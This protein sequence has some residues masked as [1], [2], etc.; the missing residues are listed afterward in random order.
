MPVDAIA[1]SRLIYATTPIKRLPLVKSRLK[2]DYGKTVTF[3]Y[4]SHR[5]G[6][7]RIAEYETQVC[8]D[9]FVQHIPEKHFR[10]I[11]FYDLLV[12]R[13]RG[14]WHQKP[15]RYQASNRNP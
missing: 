4:L 10:M 3:D 2:H 13:V 7:H 11:N 1:S 15:T 12:N 8:I 14:Q 6:C 9:R 5:D